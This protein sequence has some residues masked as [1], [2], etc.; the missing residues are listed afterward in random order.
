MLRQNGARQVNGA[1]ATFNVGDLKCVCCAQLNISVIF[2]SE[3]CGNFFCRIHLVVV[4]KS[5]SLS[6]DFNY[7]SSQDGI[8]NSSRSFVWNFN[9][10][11]SF[12]ADFDRRSFFG[13]VESWT[14]HRSD[15]API[16][17][18]RVRNS[19]Q[20]SHRNR[21]DLRF[22]SNASRWMELHEN[23][24]RISRLRRQIDN[25]KSCKID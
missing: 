8:R 19:P 20:T 23:Y 25:V 24:R 7:L 21:F 14:F 4:S 6:S 5:S 17:S 2:F 1:C 18:H 10:V 12:P 22:A 11:R 16:S 13:A 15:V 3:L 9:S